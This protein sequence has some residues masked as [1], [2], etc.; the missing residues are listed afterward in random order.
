MPP[1]KG[2]CSAAGE[3]LSG[4]QDEGMSLQCGKARW[5][6]NLCMFILELNGGALDMARGDCACV[7]CWLITVIK[8]LESHLTWCKGVGFSSWLKW[9]AV[10]KLQ[11]AESPES[12]CHW[13]QVKCSFYSCSNEQLLVT[14]KHGWQFFNFMVFYY[15]KIQH[16]NT[17]QK[18]KK[19][20]HTVCKP[21]K[22]S[23][24]IN[25]QK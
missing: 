13:N 9:I 5:V 23:Y 8:W 2:Q 3:W 10:K 18:K 24:S 22:S 4:Q 25:T 20:L 16:K 17:H 1:C 15:S 12:T 6:T 21:K 19:G 7:L 14:N 11:E